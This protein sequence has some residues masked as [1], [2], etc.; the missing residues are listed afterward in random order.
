[1]KYV[2]SIWIIWYLMYFCGVWI[3]WNA[4]EQLMLKFNVRSKQA[5][6]GITYTTLKINV[7]LTTYTYTIVYYYWNQLHPVFKEF[8]HTLAVFKE[9]SHTIAVFKEF[10][11]TIAVFKELSHTIAVFK[12]FSHTI[13]VFKEFSHTIAEL[14][15]KIITYS[16]YW[17]GK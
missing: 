1:M 4:S 17:K 7:I 15:L 10:S 5:C 14:L 16:K 3:L 8:S 12:E 2:W 9:F 11:H 13:A 6:P